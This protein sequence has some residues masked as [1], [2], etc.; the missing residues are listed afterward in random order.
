MRTLSIGRKKRLHAVTFSPSGRDLAAVGGDNVLRV[1]DSFTGELKRSAPVDETSSGYALVYLAEERLLF[2]GVGLRLWDLAADEWTV[3]DPAIPFSRRVALS[4]DGRVLAQVEKTESID[5]PRE[6][7]VMYDTATWARFPPAEDGTNSTEGLAF[8]ADGR[9]LATAHLVRVGEQQKS[10]GPQWGHY[11]THEYDYVVRVREMPSGR[12]M[13]A[14]PDWQQGVRF[15]A[16]SPDGSTV[17]GAAGP[18][19][20]AW[21]LAADRELALHKRGPKHFQGLAFTANG[22]RLLTVSNDT[23]V[24]VWDARSWAESATI[25]WAVG[26]LI[27]LSV[28]PDGL[29]AAAGSDAGKVV[30][31]DL[32]D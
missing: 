15:L 11:T 3:I 7:L 21:D 13:R 22:R 27:N 29:R 8:S 25:T 18:R 20:R 24:R 9:F 31:W 19:L 28:S 26:S 4:P 30:V 14:I 32:D 10:L 17:V 6:G 5:W 2:G 1:W 12:V 23:T 16:F